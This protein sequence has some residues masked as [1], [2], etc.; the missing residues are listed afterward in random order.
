M[1]SDLVKPPPL[2]TCYQAEFGRPNGRSRSNRVRINS[3]ESIKLELGPR[4]IRME[5]VDIYNRLRTIPLPTC[6]HIQFSSSATKGVPQEPQKLGS[7]R[8]PPLGTG[9]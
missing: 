6:Y 7:A 2:H 8:I 9:A 1:A 5:G 4:R 3:G